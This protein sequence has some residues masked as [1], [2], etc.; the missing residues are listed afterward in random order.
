MKVL[1]IFGVFFVS[2]AISACS[3]SHLAAKD[4]EN[5]GYKTGTAEFSSCA[6][7]QLA[8]RRAAQAEKQR[9]AT[10]IAIEKE[11]ASHGIFGRTPTCDTVTYGNGMSSQTC[12]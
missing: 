1:S 5:L 12:K 6:E 11:K 2:I 10:Q 4:C 9:Q 7:K 3:A 8:A